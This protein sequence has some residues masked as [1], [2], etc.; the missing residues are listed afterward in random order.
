MGALRFRR[1]VRGAG[2][3]VYALGGIHASNA[4]LAM[5]GAAG[6]AGVDAVLE[7]WS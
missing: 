1:M 4:A 7:G 2:L 6:W 3:P 5:A